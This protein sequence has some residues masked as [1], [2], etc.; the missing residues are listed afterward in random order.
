MNAADNQGKTPLHLAAEAD[1][2]RCLKRLLEEN[3]GTLFINATD[4]QGKTP[5]HLAAEADNIKCLIGLLDQRKHPVNINDEDK[6]NNKPLDLAKHSVCQEALQEDWDNLND[7][8]RKD[9]GEYYL[10]KYFKG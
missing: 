4:N 3:K 10:N 8:E 6:Q 7:C 5:L 2:I 9:K 1:N